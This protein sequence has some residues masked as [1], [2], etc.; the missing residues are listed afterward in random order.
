MHAFSN[1]HKAMTGT[2]FTGPGVVIQ[3]TKL[4]RAQG[5]HWHEVRQNHFARLAR[6]AGL[7][8][9]TATQ[10]SLRPTNILIAGRDLKVSSALRVEQAT[11]DGR[12]IE[13]RQA[14]PVN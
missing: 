9:V 4:P 13:I 11:E 5:F 7:Q 14:A 2:I 1:A 12:A 6:E 8:Y 10:I 3:L